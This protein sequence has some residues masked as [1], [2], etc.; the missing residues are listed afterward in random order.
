[1]GNAGSFARYRQTLALANPPATPYL[2]CPPPAP[3][4]SFLSSRSLG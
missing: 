4:A 2:Y 3:Q 1:M